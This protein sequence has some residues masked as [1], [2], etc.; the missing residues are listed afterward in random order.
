MTIVTCSC[1]TYGCFCNTQQQS[2]VDASEVI[3]H[4]PNYLLA[5][6]LQTSL[7]RALSN[8]GRWLSHGARQR[9]KLQVG[10]HKIK[11]G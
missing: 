9:G 1:T 6:P 2:W 10:K 11:W 5:G 4:K 8:L 3:A 7:L